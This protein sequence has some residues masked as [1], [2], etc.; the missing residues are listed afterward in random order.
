VVEIVDCGHTGTIQLH[1]LS[2]QIDLLHGDNLPLGVREHEIYEQ[3][4]APLDAGDLLLFFSDGITEARNSAGELF[5]AEHLKQCIREHGQ[6][7][8]SALVEVI[9]KAVVV[10]CESDRL[11]DDLTV[12][13]VRVEEVGPP[14]GQA[15]VVIKS[16]L[17][18]LYRVSDW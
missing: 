5:G 4:S 14:L 3:I 7:E 12:V 13:A 15:A 16:D 1:H 17:G 11:A 6:L 8:P 10:F 9:R 2:G 18:Q